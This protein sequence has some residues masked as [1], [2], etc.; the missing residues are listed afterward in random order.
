MAAVLPPSQVD[1]ARLA[2]RTATPKV[3]DGRSTLD[4]IAWRKAGWTFRALGRP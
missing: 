1:P 3:I 2:A 4:P